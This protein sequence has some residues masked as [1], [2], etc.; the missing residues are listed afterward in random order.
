MVENYLKYR[1]TLKM[2]IVL[3]DVRR[4]ASSDDASLIRWLETFGIPFLIVL[5]KSDKISKNKCSTQKR[6]IKNFLLLRDEE[7]ICFSAVTGM[8]KQEILKRIM[9]SI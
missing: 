1:K 7:M 3:L 8:G 9:R 4:E 5:T 6:I 2:V